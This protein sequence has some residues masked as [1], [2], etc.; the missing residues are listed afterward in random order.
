MAM[1][2]SS[3]DYIVLKPAF[4]DTI[5]PEE[6]I[7]WAKEGISSYKVPQAIDFREELPMSGVGK[8]LRRV[9]VEE[10]LNKKA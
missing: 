5:K 1:G 10:A 4:K 6:I 7:A 9:L 8:L 2:V 3:R